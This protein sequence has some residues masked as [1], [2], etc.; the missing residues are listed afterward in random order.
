MRKHERLIS[1]PDTETIFGTHPLVNPAARPTAGLPPPESCDPRAAVANARASAARCALGP[2]VTAPWIQAKPL[3]FQRGREGS[4]STSY[5]MSLAARSIS[6][7]AFPHGTM[8][9]CGGGRVP[10]S[11]C[12][13]A[14]AAR[15]TSSA[16]SAMSM[17]LRCVAVAMA[18]HRTTP[19]AGAAPARAASRKKTIM[20]AVRCTADEIC[21]LRAF[22]PMTLSGHPPASHVAAAK[23]V[24]ALS[25]H[26][27]EPVRCPEPGDA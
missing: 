17:V 7:N 19:A 25:K 13:N 12:T 3:P 5:P 27:F 21:S 1:F 23:S 15:S 14:T 11:P 26:S 16:G 4:A 24:S 6:Q 22:L 9:R 8:N 10:R 20:S 18:R 2:N